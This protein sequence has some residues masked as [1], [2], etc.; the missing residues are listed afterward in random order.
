MTLFRKFLD[1]KSIHQRLHVMSPFA[2]YINGV[3]RKL[4][5][6]SIREKRKKLYEQH[7]KE[8]DIS[9]K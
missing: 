3:K 6:C 8:E 5:I 4:S 1:I 9:R 2:Q 7:H